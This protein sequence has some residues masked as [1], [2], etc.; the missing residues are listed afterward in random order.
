MPKKRK[1]VK[2]ACLNCR[3]AHTCCD[4]YRPCRHCIHLGI[5]HACV[6]ASARRRGKKRTTSTDESPLEK[7][8]KTESPPKL[9]ILDQLHHH[10]KTDRTATTITQSSSSSSITITMN[11]ILSP[12]FCNP[13]MFDRNK[14]IRSSNGLPFEK[15]LKLKLEEFDKSTSS[16]EETVENTNPHQ[17]T[18]LLLEVINLQNQIKE[19]KREVIEKLIFYLFED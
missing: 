13:K 4:D 10:T 17:Q 18:E 19:Q 12:W 14:L 3:I 11:T 1:Q 16:T 2:R 9:G 7:K 8:P 15:S 5:A 6:D